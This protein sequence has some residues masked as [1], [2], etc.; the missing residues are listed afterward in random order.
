MQTQ[1]GINGPFLN[2]IKA[3]YSKVSS[4]V[5]ING[6][7][8]EWFDISCGVKQG[9]VLSPTLFSMFINDLVGDIKGS[10]K[11]VQCG[12]HYFTSLLYADDLVIIAD[13]EE[14]LQAMLDIVHRWCCTWQIKVNPGKTKVIHFRHK[15]KTLSNFIFHLG[16]KTIDYAH[17]YKYLGYFLNEFLDTDESIQRV[18]DSANRALGVL[19]AKAK[20]AHGFPL[21]VFSRLF[22][23]CVTPICTY[24]A[25]IWAHRKKQPLEKIQNNA[26]RFFFGLGTAAPLAALLGDSGWPPIQLHLQFTMLKYWFRVCSMSSERVPKQAFLWSCSLSDSGK[27]TWA[28]HASDLLDR[29]DLHIFSPDGLQSNKFYDCLWDALANKFLQNWF[30][31]VNNVEASSSESGGKLALYRLIKH[32]PETEPYCRASLSVGVRRV[33]AGL[34][35]GCLPLQI[36]LGRYTTPKTPL[37]L[38]ICKLCNDGIEDQEHFLFRCRALTAPRNDF[39]SR[40]QTLNPDFLSYTLPDKCQYLLLPQQHIHCIAH[41][42]YHLYTFRQNLLYNIS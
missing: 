4:C 38:R 3:L 11:G 12:M 18:Y 23:A 33:L 36:E 37:N 19:I 8:S 31:T 14:D 29:L 15:R 26:L 25:H 21:S 22:D 5:K 2:L 17:D 32:F 16:C 20:T 28:S 13:K 41:G 10:G 30:Q 42:I 27:V 6:K 40:I 34:R 9:C 1:F 24:S 7:L 35:A 39:F